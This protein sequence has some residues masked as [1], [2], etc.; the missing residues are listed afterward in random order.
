[1]VV[2]ITLMEAFYF[3]SDGLSLY[4]PILV[5]LSKEST[6]GRLEIPLNVKFVLNPP[7]HFAM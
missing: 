6:P 7:K 1:M 3:R 5:Y 2:G 4:Y